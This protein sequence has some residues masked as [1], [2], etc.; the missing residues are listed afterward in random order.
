M[1]WGGAAGKGK[2]EE[3]RGRGGGGETTSLLRYILDCSGTTL[4]TNERTMSILLSDIT[5]HQAVQELQAFTTGTVF[6]RFHE[7]HLVGM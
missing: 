2:K 1:I 6:E 7:Y 3:G 4:M 5:L